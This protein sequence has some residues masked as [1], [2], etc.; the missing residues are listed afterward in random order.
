MNM[1]RIARVV[2]PGLPH[3][4]TQRGNRRMKTFFCEN[5]YEAYIDLMAEWCGECGVEVWGYC[6]MPNHIHMMAVPAE[7][8]GLARAIGEAHRRYSRMVNFRE[9]WRGHLFQERFAS[10]PM[11]EQHA[12]YAGR[13]IEMNPVRAKLKKFPEHWRYSS[14]RAH[15]AKKD[16]RLVR[17]K[18][19]L[20]MVDDWRGYLH[21]CDEAWDF[22]R[23]HERSGRPLGSAE[24]VAGLEEATGRE[25]A[26][27][28]RGP[29]PKKRR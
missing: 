10:F 12:Y 25:L 26:P 19:L 27:K 4:V 2:I 20:E 18:P 13:Y 11:D 3:H 5:D 22:I 28:P 15:L 6:L 7:E 8:T 29:K 1:S 9:G 17:V 24:F 14:A 16:D 23:S 21:E